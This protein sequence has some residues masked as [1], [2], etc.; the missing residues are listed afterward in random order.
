MVIEYLKGLYRLT[1]YQYSIIRNIGGKSIVRAIPKDKQRTCYRVSRALWF[2]EDIIK[3]YNITKESSTDFIIESIGEPKD[4]HKVSK[5]T[6]LIKGET[7][8]VCLSLAEAQER[9]TK[10]LQERID[11]NN[12]IISERQSENELIENLLKEE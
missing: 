12:H 10:M 5:A 6:M 1:L 8:I 4:K 2:T 11:R 3:Q 9:K 7:D